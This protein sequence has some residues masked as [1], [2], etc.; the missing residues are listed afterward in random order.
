MIPVFHTSGDGSGW[1][2]D[3]D[4]RQ[5]RECLRGEVKETSLARAQVVHSPFWMAL[6]MH[7]RPV[8]QDRFVIAHADNP[9]YFYV[10][11]PEFARVQKQVDLWIAR[12]R[13][14]E[15]QFRALRLPVEYIPYTIDPGLFFPLAKTRNEK[16]ALRRKYGIPEEAYLIA[17]FHRDS[18]GANLYE[19]KLQKAPE[20]LVMILSQLKARGQA[21]HVLLAGPRRHWLRREL[22]RGN[23][24][25]TFV[26][27]EGIE[28]DDFGVNITSRRQL[29]ELYNATDLY[30]ITSRWE[31]GPQSLMEAAACRCK[32]V[33]PPIGLARDILEPQCLFHFASQAVEIIQNDMQRDSLSDSV[34]A[35]FRRWKDNHTT[36]VMAA[37]LKALYRRLPAMPG[38][39]A[40]ASL[41][42]KPWSSSLAQWSHTL[43]RRFAR[44]AAPGAVSVCHTPG[45]HE[46]LDT[47]MTEVRASLGRS[48]IRIAADAPL[49]LR[50]WHSGMPGRPAIQFI[51]PGMEQVPPGA[52]VVAPSVQ[53]IINLRAANCL[54]PAVVIPFIFDPATGTEEALVIEEGDSQASLTV[55]R[56]LLAGQPVLYPKGS[57][58]YEQVFHA[59]A[60]W[61]GSQ[62][63]PELKEKIRLNQSE[64]RALA[65]PPRRSASDLALLKLLQECAL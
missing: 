37:R 32:I 46:G 55:W 2:I 15:E 21:F 27:K 58:Y 45:V 64:I 23:I 59:G 25:F 38:F 7:P 39:S 43:K 33:S 51:V 35:Q 42:R 9:P 52:M 41:P 63:I 1:A 56:A 18:E 34:E 16:A 10:K 50:G 48:G 3:E 44:P 11:Q 14:A 26:G 30:L 60:P 8:L 5:L 28:G 24:P 22:R 61:G 19:P 36:P 29:N 17:N 49:V 4:L 40:K 12:S 65:R 20:L 13:E 53:D 62:A 54:A 31:G 57:A 47:V 6:P